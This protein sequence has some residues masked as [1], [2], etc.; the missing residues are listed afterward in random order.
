M[1]LKYLRAISYSAEPADYTPLC[2]GKT[3]KG[4][5]WSALLACYKILLFYTIFIIEF[6]KSAAKA[7]KKIQKSD[8]RRICDRI[9]SLPENL[10]DST[11]T[12]LKGENP[13]H[14]IRVGDFRIIYEIHGDMLV[15][16]V[17]KIGHRKEV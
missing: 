9:E 4:E 6:K 15:I 2:R 8:R 3:P 16:M 7:L 12:K 13:F 10:P 14:K 1:N 5:D 17:L 11:T